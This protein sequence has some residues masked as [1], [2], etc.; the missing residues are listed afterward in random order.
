MHAEVGVIMKS[1]G[2][3]TQLFNRG[4]VAVAVSAACA[5]G[6]HA[7][8]AQE[9]LEEII[10]TATKRQV[11]L[12]DV[13]VAVTAFTDQ[14]IVRQGF[15][16]LDDYF[17]QIPGLTFSRREPGGTTVLMR[18]CTISGLSFG[19]SSTTSIYLDEQPITAAGRNPDARLIDI[20][21]VEA[22]SGPQGTLFGDASQ[23]GSLR[24][25]TNKPD[26]SAQ[27][28]WVDLGIN[29][30][31][32]GG[33]G[34]AVSGMANIP[35]VEGKVGLRL[36]GFLEEEA[37]Y[38]DN[39]LSTS[40]GGTFDNAAFVGDDVNSAT[41][42]GARAMLR[43]ALND[44]WTLDLSAVYQKKNQ[45]GFGDTDI[46][47]QFYAGRTIGDLEQVRFG[48]DAWDDEWYQLAVTA[49]GSLGFA[50]FMITG[51]YF[52][53]ETIYE[54]DATSYQ[55]AFNQLSDYWGPYYTAY[56]FGGDPQAF[57]Y[58]NENTD[59]VTVEMRLSTPSDSASRWNGIVG[60]FYNRDEGHTIFYSGN[61]AFDTSPAFSYLNYLAYYYDP[62][63]P[64]PAPPSGG[65][66]FTGVYDSTLEQTALFGEI[67]FEVTDNFNITVGGRFFD[68]QLDRTLK[69]GALF[70]LGTEPDCNVDF[71]FADAVG[72]SSESDFVPKVT[73]DYHI[74]DD[75][76]VYATYSEGFRRGGANAARASSIFGPGNP[77]HQYKSDKLK[78]HE[79]GLKGTWADGRVRFNSAVYHMIWDDIQLQANDPN[80]FTLGIVNFPQAELNG[81]EAQFNWIPADDWEISGTLGWNEAEISKDATLFPTEPNPTSVVQGTELP[82][83]PD[84]KG[85]LSIEHTLAREMFGGQPFFRV[86]YTYNGEATSSLEGIQSIIFVNPVRTLSNYSITD[87]RLGID[88][89][90]WSA[91]FFV[92]NVFDERASQFLNDRWAQTRSSINRPLT[93]GVTYRRKFE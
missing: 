60:F 35:L 79:I 81:V 46:A 32:D 49:E 43:T 17:G 18:G 77:R 92:D 80:I 8:N 87:L 59:L 63:C 34:Y 72:T 13:P 76:M 41:N 88:T 9:M 39:I 10:V 37:G 90:S 64:V 27:N 4:A 55:F 71:C 25:I 15:K 40:P 91:A 19:G 1:A 20:E 16:T 44:N 5:G 70:P 89:D 93:F 23:C 85:S 31:A 3:S 57:A 11:N 26:L 42:S 30:V 56:D 36:V 83:M 14:D 29:Q 69:Q 65:N 62:T 75:T 68:I 74:N 7:A 51:S 86:D 2:Q 47:D 50:D 28:G 45:D 38:V 78:N 54:A 21:R 33:T 52:S 58:N 61:T 22:L 12:Q 66:W 24:I 48:K 84:W 82:I 67:G 73:F 6:P 53:R